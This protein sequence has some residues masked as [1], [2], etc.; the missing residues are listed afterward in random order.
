V[1]ACSSNPKVTN[2]ELSSNTPP[3]DLHLETGEFVEADATRDEL[4]S[5]CRAVEEHVN[6]GLAPLDDDD[7]TQCVG[8]KA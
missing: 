2:V 4:R 8:P 5:P 7:T 1:T 3:D 6:P